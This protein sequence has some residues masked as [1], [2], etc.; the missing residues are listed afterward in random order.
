[1]IDLTKKFVLL[2]T[3]TDSPLFKIVWFASLS[4]SVWMQKQGM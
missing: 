3:V 2:K 4:P 1:M